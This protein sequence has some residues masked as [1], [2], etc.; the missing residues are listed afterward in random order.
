MAVGQRVHDKTCRGE[1]NVEKS[2]EFAG[3]IRIWHVHIPDV[4]VALTAT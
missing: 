4:T 3:V 1:N 2:R